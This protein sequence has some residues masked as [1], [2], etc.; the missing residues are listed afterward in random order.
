MELEQMRQID[1]I[2]RTGTMSAA[3]D[4]LHISQPALSRSIQR[5]EAELGCALFDR[6]GRRVELNEAGSVAVDW[7]RELLRDERLMR[8]EITAVAQRTRA[9]R[10]AS[11]APA[12]LWRLTGLMVER[13]PSETLTSELVDERAVMRG[14]AEGVYDLGIV[15]E[16]S[17]MPGLVSCELMR[18]GLSVTLP[19]NHPLAARRQVTFADLAGE[20]F[21]IFT[22]IG[23]WREIVDREIPGATY[24]EQRDRMVFA[25]LSY[26]TPHCT[27]ISDAPFQ[28]DPVPGRAIV[29]IV[30]DGAHA[31]FYL[32]AR[33]DAQGIASGLFSWV[34]ECIVSGRP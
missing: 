8:E 28:S 7:A 24:I 1:T 20:T 6:V 14:I 31:V 11:V 2:A 17:H 29:P 33:A 13:F 25:Q 30:D 22:D 10:V 34:E 21:L 9:L 32:V 3:A 23:F 16:P 26:S 15:T 5:L 12:P 27:F 18:E 19:P 4:E